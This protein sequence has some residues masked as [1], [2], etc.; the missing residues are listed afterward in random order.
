[1][2][3]YWW[4]RSGCV[5]LAASLRVGRRRIWSGRCLW[6]ASSQTDPKSKSVGAAT[7]LAKPVVR[8]I[9]SARMHVS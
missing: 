1:M 5:T 2:I 6:L 3:V 8:L 4:T 7:V 9:L